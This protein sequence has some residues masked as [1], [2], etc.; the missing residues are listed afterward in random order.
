VR[1]AAVTALGFILCRAGNQCCRVVA[2]LAESYNPHVRYGSAMAL[3]Q[4][5]VN[6]I[7]NI[8]IIFYCSL[9][10]LLC[11][12]W[13]CRGVAFVETDVDRYRRF[14]SSRSVDCS[15]IIIDAIEVNNGLSTMQV[16]F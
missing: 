3:V 8:L 7:C 14:C 5:T 15:C 13:Q 6:C 1:R 10:N 16:F 2:L 9:G 4:L 12:N 11:W